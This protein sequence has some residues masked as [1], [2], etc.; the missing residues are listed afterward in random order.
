MASKMSSTLLVTPPGR[1][2]TPSDYVHSGQPIPAI[3]RIRFFE[4]RAWEEFVL[5]WVDSLRSEYERVER[6]GGAGDC[7]RDV[8]G[9]SKCG[10]GVWDNYQCKHYRDP[11][12]PSDVW[13]ELGKLVYYTYLGEYTYP[14]KYS[15]V[16]PKGAGNKLSRLFKDKVSLKAQLIQNWDAY[17]LNGITT[18]SQISLDQSLKAHL[19]KLDFSI[20]DA[21]PPL[22]LIDGHA[23]TKWHVSRFGGGLPIRPPA[24]TPPDTPTAEEITYIRHLLDAYG[25]HLGRVIARL[26]DLKDDDLKSHLLDSRREFYSAES[27]R[28]FS[29]DTLPPGEF[30]RLQD[31]VHSGI[32]DEVRV[33]HENGYRRVLAVVR[34]ARSLQ[35]TAH[36]LV[37]RLTVRDR[38][39]ICHQ[40]ANDDKLRWIK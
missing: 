4:P 16:A 5:E 13:T 20:F 32:V 29:R 25:S 11:L 27:L 22:R 35:L 26:D 3:E 10:T 17:C 19:D 9:I 40:L 37:S 36:A 15:F 31:E 30:E 34:V 18:T 38:G 23:K 12:T 6:C 21:I 14:R 24:V 33:D 8:I 2:A 28:T 39:G 7:G 1:N